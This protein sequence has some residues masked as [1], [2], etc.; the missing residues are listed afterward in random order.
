MK[1]PDFVRNMG[2]DDQVKYADI[3]REITSQKEPMKTGGYTKRVGE[4]Y[5]GESRD[6]PMKTKWRPTAPVPEWSGYHSG[7]KNMGHA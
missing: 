2:A 6:L 5:Y 7:R 3:N 1:R 4:D